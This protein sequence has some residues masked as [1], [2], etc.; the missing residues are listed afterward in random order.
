MKE[1]PGASTNPETKTRKIA[2]LIAAVVVAISIFAFNKHNINVYFTNT[3]GIPFKV[4]DKVYAESAVFG[5][6]K[7]KNGLGIYRLIRPLNESDIDVMQ[8]TDRQKAEMKK[9]L[10][11]SLREYMVCPNQLFTKEHLVQNKS[12]FIGTFLDHKVSEVLNFSLDGK[13]TTYL[14]ES[15]LAIKLNESSLDDY[16][17]LFKMP[18][19]YTWA[20]GNRYVINS[21]TDDHELPSFIN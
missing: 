6:D 10:N 4:G 15:F 3:F 12:A 13:K 8:I 16:S 9:K 1:I 18:A 5:S 20:D 19:N 7:N 14:K 17:Y 2:I 21:T 11:P